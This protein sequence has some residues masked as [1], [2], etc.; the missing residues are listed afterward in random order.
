MGTCYNFVCK[1]C[2]ENYDIDKEHNA[3]FLIPKLL[4]R[5]EG[6]EIGVYHDNQYECWER[7]EG[8]GETILSEY[9]EVKIWDKKYKLK[10]EYRFRY[11]DT[12]LTPEEFIKYLEEHNAEK[13][14]P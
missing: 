12:E 3:S 5:H 14:I 11:G 9:K 13:L 1:T 2:K 6:H 8:D 7:F 4:K 10:P